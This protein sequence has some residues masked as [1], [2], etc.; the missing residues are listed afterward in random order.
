MR[1]PRHKRKLLEMVIGGKIIDNMKLITILSGCRKRY[2]E[3]T[4]QEKR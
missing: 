2:R 4:Y 3:L 1:R